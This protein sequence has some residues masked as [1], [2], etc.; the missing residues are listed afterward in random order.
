MPDKCPDATSSI[1]AGAA[2]FVVK[3]SGSPAGQD[4]VGNF[5]L[6]ILKPDGKSETLSSDPT[7]ISPDAPVVLNK[8][9]DAPPGGA[10]KF[11]V[12][13]SPA[14]AG[15]Q[16]TLELTLAGEGATPT[17]SVKGTC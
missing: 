17:L 16:W 11:H 10:W 2:R 9:Y 15:A 7:T 3:L 6:T 5:D 1:P 4:G 8:T 13:A 12:S 14:S